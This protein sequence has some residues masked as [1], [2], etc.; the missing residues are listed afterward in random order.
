M[1]KKEQTKK[2]NPVVGVTALKGYAATFGAGYIS[3]IVG[4]IF[5]LYQTNN[6][7]PEA[8]STP[9]FRDLCFISG[10]QQVSKDLSKN[11]LK[12]IP[13]LEKLSISNPF[14]FGATTGFPMWFL[15]R[16]VATPLQNSR[17]KG[18]NPFEGFSTSVVNDTPYHTL[19]NGL[20]EFCS[21]KINP[22]LL[23]KVNNYVT[24]RFVEGVISGSVAG[25]TYILTWPAKTLITGQKIDDAWKLLITQTPKAF[26]K[27]ISYQVT[28]PTLLDLLK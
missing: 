7:N 25:G 28:R 18:V 12:T 19:K 10:W 21:V 17:K 5:T 1:A 27:K 14:I 20:D 24:K 26:S 23:P 8:F 2:E 16:L 11:L 6:L 3:G 15:T 4:E 9:Q 13:A 22:V